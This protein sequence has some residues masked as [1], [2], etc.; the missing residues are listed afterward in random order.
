MNSTKTILASLLLNI[1]SA[2]IWLPRDLPA[3]GSEQTLYSFTGSGADG[4]YP[5]GSLIQGSDGALYGT[6]WSGGTNGPGMVFR[7]TVS[8][9]QPVAPSLSLSLSGA[10][11]VLA[12]PTNSTGYTLQSTTNVVVIPIVWSAVT[13]APIV[14]DGLNLVTNPVAGPCEFYRLSSP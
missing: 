6:T 4:K 2:I 9:A 5:E 1:V 10:N 12:W 8:A 3:Q 14:L 13:N 11:V 7:L